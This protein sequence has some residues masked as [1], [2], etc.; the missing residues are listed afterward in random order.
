MSTPLYRECL[1]AAEARIARG[2]AEKKAG[3]DDK[4][5]VI[6]DEAQRRGRGGPAQI[7]TELGVSDQAVSLWIRR[8]RNL[9]AQAALSLPLDTLERLLAAERRDL[10]PLSTGQWK[11]LAWVVRQVFVDVTWIEEP[12]VL[13]ADEVADSDLD[14]GL[15]EQLAAYCRALSRVQALAAIDACQRGEIAD[16]PV[17][18]D[19]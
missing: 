11:A 16:L 2:E 17:R 1:E 7:A 9:P 4:A 6:A 18:R 19:I 12:A 13:L 5:R 8:A 10:A 3:G 14:R 15:A